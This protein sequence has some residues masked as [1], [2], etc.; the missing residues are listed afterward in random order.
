MYL[1][2]LI[3]KI[4]WPVLSLIRT[5]NP[6]LA[7]PLG[8]LHT[9]Y[10]KNNTLENSQIQQ[11]INKKERNRTTT[12]YNDTGLHSPNFNLKSSS[13]TEKT[14]YWTNVPNCTT[15]YSADPSHI[16]PNSENTRPDI[17]KAM[18]TINKINKNVYY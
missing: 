17:I 14:H 5:A 10:I 4:Y 16:T 9:N 12:T 13:V 6:K 11:D 1:Y 7:H 3:N 18:Y 2:N 8:C 15:V